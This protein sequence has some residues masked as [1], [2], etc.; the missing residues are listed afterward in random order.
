M[1]HRHPFSGRLAWCFTL[2][3]VWLMAEPGYASQHAPSPHELREQAFEKIVEARGRARARHYLDALNQLDDA[4]SLAERMEDRLPLALALH[5]IAE[6]QLL[7][8]APRDALNAYY[9][10]LGIY[11]ALGHE[12]G[13]GLVQRRIRTL[14]RLLSRAEKPPASEVKPV[15]PS[16]AQ[17]RLSLVDQAVERVR[18]RIRSRGQ[19][20]RSVAPSG[21]TQVTRAEPPTTVDTPGEGAYVEALT[22]KIGGNSRYPEYARRTG[23]GGTVELVFAVQEN[24][25]VENVKLLK[26]SGFIV[27]DVEALRNVRE[28][29]PFGSVPARADP[30]PLTVRLTFSYKLPDAPDG[31]R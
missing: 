21:P 30:G 10:V 7:R 15:A 25:D 18:Q 9:Q 28:S 12:S 23:Q 31:A 2:M 16:E 11:T 3:L 24:G 13:V 4:V 6:I 29:A 1:T 20:G 8:G 14:S 22:R 26:S 27:L 17:D 5:N 19:D